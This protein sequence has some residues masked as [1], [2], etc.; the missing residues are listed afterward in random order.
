M[1]IKHNNKII[2]RD[3]T[4][5]SCWNCNSAH[6]HLKRSNKVIICFICGGLYY[7]GHKLQNNSIIEG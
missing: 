7:K 5:R 1:I 2:K 6:E 4:I 3:I